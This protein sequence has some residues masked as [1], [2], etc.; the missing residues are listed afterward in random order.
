MIEKII[1]DN[2][3]ETISIQWDGERFA[4]IQQLK[5]LDDVDKKVITLNP[6]EMLKIVRFISH[7]IRRTGDNN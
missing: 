1:T 5:L 2:A 4:I 3:G 7:D 6:K